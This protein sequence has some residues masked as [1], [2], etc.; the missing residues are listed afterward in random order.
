MPSIM[1]LLSNCRS[2]LNFFDLYILLRNVTTNAR[3]FLGFQ[4]R[5]QVLL[6]RYWCF[7]ALFQDN[8]RRY[9]VSVSRKAASA[10]FPEKVLSLPAAYVIPNYI[11]TAPPAAGA[12]SAD[13]IR[14]RRT[15]GRL[16]G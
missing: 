10:G 14:R 6:K 2:H 1:L 16:C 15:S 3:K 4:I 5:E 12:L 13:R 7:A 9:I 11:T 8:C